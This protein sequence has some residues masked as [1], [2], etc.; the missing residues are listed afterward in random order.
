MATNVLVWGIGND[1]Q[2]LCNQLMLNEACAY[3]NIVAYVSNNRNIKML[4]GKNVLHEEEILDCVEDIEYIIVASDKFYNEIVAYGQ[5]ILQIPRRKFINGKVFQVPCFNWKRYLKIYE[6]DLSIV[7]EACYGGKLSHQL[8]LP[9][10][11][12]FVNVRIGNNRKDYSS[13]LNRLKDYMQ[14]TP[15][16]ENQWGHIRKKIGLG[17]REE[18]IFQD[19]GMMIL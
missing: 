3:I 13:L 2:K 1:Y 19:Y 10:N 4:D 12:P 9:F 17:M 5:K 14:M 15:Q 16:P 11:S 6:S 8:G 7:S 18:L